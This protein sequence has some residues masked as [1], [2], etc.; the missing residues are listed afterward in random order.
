M[1]FDIGTLLLVLHDTLN[2]KNLKQKYETKRLT[3]RRNKCRSVIK[4]LTNTFLKH[5]PRASSSAKFTCPTF[6]STCPTIKTFHSGKNKK[7]VYI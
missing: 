2:Q 4:G 6:K 3:V 7:L 5:L 1:L